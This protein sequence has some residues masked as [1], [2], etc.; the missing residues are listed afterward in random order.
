[1]LT[2]LVAFDLF[3]GYHISNF[4]TRINYFL[5]GIYRENNI[6][7]LNFTYS[8][9]KKLYFIFSKMIYKKSSIWLANENF[10]LFD[11]NK[12]FLAMRA[13]FSELF[14][15]NEKWYKGSL[16]NYKFVKTI[17]P[18]NFPH[19]VFFPNLENN[20]YLVNECFKI[21]VP[22]FAITDSHVNPANVFCPVPGNSKS[23]RSTFFYYVLVGK[24]VMSGRY[25]SSSSFLL[26]VFKKSG[27]LLLNF[28]NYNTIIPTHNYFKL[29][30]RKYL[31]EEIIFLLNSRVLSKNIRNV[32]SFF[33]SPR[34]LRRMEKLKGKRKFLGFK[35]RS[36][37][38]EWYL[39][40]KIATLCFQTLLFL[41]MRNFIATI[42]KFKL[43]ASFLFK[44]IG[45]ILL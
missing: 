42:S 19:A 7:N 13:S 40:R 3:L 4:N 36:A 1:M 28:F 25:H 8:L 11:R 2:Q 21:G 22:S 14:F 31:I 33:I 20:H 10:S 9:T 34:R 27:H 30:F 39:L 41:T 26:S 17:R 37:I 35:G 24:A 12:W 5:L 44:T 32:F 45:Y 16:T 23:V 29:F 18:K 38:I 15:F 43:K 6:F